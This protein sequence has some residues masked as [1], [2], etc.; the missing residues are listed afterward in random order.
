VKLLIVIGV[1]LLLS[2]CEGDTKYYQTITAPP[3]PPDTTQC[4]GGHHGGHHGKRH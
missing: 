3:A 1:L 4:D 2:A